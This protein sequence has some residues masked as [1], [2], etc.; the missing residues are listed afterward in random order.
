[1][2][3]MPP[4]HSPEFGTTDAGRTAGARTHDRH[5]CARA[6]SAGFSLAEALVALAVAA[7][8]AAML[9]RFVANTRAGAA[10]VSQSIEMAALADTLLART[11]SSQALKPA[12]SEGREGGYAWR[13]DIAPVTFTARATRLSETPSAA[14]SRQA[15]GRQAGADSGGG[16]RG[17]AAG[18]S[19]G[20][21]GG[22]PASGTGPAQGI[23]AS[24]QPAS[25]AGVRWLP[26]RVAVFIEAP[27]GQS[28]AIE[29]I[30]LGPA[31]A[32]GR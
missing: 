23:G 10:R 25:P 32:S 15:G 5:G 6:G 24:A 12:R 14:P 22:D 8:L 26:R 31:D 1:M 27:S 16:A 18:F 7:M 30:R 19:L 20:Q 2:S 3:P 9:T 13:I 11:P 21:G 28:H 29:T 17:A 4:A